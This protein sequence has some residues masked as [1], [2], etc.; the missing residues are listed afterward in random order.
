MAFMLLQS[1]L[2]PN[3]FAIVDDIF[4]ADDFKTVLYGEYGSFENFA[5]LVYVSIPV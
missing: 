3:R 2:E 5:V 4:K 1:G